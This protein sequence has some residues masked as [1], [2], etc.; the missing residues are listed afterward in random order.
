MGSGSR[1]RIVVFDNHRIVVV[2]LNQASAL[3]ARGYTG[4]ANGMIEGEGV[5]V[6]TTITK[7]VTPTATRGAASEAPS[8]ISTTSQPKATDAR[9]GVMPRSTI[10][11]HHS[12][13]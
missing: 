13:A 8:V 11:T 2:W 1:T 9:A 6:E 7:N 5:T 4:T 10:I 12:N 3:C